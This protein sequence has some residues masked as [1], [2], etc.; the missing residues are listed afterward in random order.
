MQQSLAVPRGPVLPAQVG[1]LL[2][3]ALA[4]YGSFLGS[5]A[6][7]GTPIQDAAGGYLSADAT[8]LAP[9]GPA[10]SIWSLVYLGLAVFAAYQLTAPGA[11][12]ETLRR[13][14][15]PASLSALLNAAWILTAQQGWLAVSVTVI[16]ILLASLVWVVVLLRTYGS[17]T[18]V[19]HWIL[20]TTFGVY[21]GWVCVA[22]LANTAAWLASLGVGADAAWPGIATVA[23]LV[24]AAAIGVALTGYTRGQLAPAAAIVWGLAWIGV[25][26][27]TGTNESALIV[28]A[29][30]AIAG[31]LLLTAL[32]LALRARK[33]RSIT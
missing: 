16:F 9:A 13:L 30:L 33:E 28:S 11:R 31:L 14:R 10:F 8:L 23:L 5:G 3:I 24:V 20:W 4:V 27:L 7:G 29:A 19:E 26:R 18:R 32:G 22:S 17:A 12:S 1:T 15:G 25:S 2:A 21:L 6:A